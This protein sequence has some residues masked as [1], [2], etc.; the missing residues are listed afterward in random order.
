[1]R[2]Y[3]QIVHVSPRVSITSDGVNHLRPVIAN[4]LNQSLGRDW[5]GAPPI[6]TDNPSSRILRVCS[7][8][9]T[10]EQLSPSAGRSG[11]AK[12]VCCR[13]PNH[14]LPPWHD[15]IPISSIHQLLL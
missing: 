12:T 1:M 9:N 11:K 2:G 4:D 15:G 7:G 13:I 6:K 5:P 3:L 8:R 10:A 14:H